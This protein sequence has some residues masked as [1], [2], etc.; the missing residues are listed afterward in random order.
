MHREAVL[1]NVVYYEYTMSSVKLISNL[2]NPA[3][4]SPQT[5]PKVEDRRDSQ[6]QIL[7]YPKPYVY[8]LK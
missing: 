7:L 1:A 8:A 2:K 4:L 6:P 3:T 5:P